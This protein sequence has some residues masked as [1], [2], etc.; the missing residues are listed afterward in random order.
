MPLPPPG[1]ATTAPSPGCASSWPQTVTSPRT[2]PGS[3]C[4]RTTAGATCA[5][6]RSAG[7]QGAPQWPP[8]HRRAAQPQCCYQGVSCC[9]LGPRRNLPQV[10][11]IG[12]GSGG[13]RQAYN[14]ESGM[15]GKSCRRAG[16]HTLLPC[17]CAAAPLHLHL[18]NLSTRRSTSVNLCDIFTRPSPVWLG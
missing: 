8:R 5:G 7:Q 18:S 17:G 12:P 14:L 6:P 3:C 10:S 16:S 1:L 13:S 9:P 4:S 11:W 2:A 15:A